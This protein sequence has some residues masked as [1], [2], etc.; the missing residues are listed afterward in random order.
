[1]STLIVPGVPA[2]PACL[3]A[4]GDGHGLLCTRP[5]GHGAGRHAASYPVGPGRRAV[6]EVWG[7]DV[8]AEARQ[9]GRDA[10]NERANERVMQV[11]DLIA[12]GVDPD[13]AWATVETAVAHAES[14]GEVPC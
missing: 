12:A 9:R 2:V 14:V 10:I 13:K 11:I 5:R 3:D 7:E 8:H 6:V 1:M 4:R